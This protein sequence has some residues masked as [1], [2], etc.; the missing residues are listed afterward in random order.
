MFKVVDAGACTTC[1]RVYVHVSL[2]RAPAFFSFSKTASSRYFR[3]RVYFRMDCVR[4]RAYTFLTR[5]TQHKRETRR[6]YRNDS[7]WVYFFFSNTTLSTIR[8]VNTKFVSIDARQGEKKH[9]P[10]LVLQ[11]I[12][13]EMG[14]VWSLLCRRVFL[15][16]IIAS[17]YRNI[18][19]K[20]VYVD[21]A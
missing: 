9:I 5:T 6:L 12:A 21:C 4:F 17:F 15:I 1:A 11:L 14:M 13:H 10:N 8:I 20:R 3:L 7:Q 18:T 16:W 19:I 2:L